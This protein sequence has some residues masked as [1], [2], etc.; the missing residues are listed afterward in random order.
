[1]NVENYQSGAI[2]DEINEA[3]SQTTND[4][5]L[6]DSN[7][8][9]RKVTFELVLKPKSTHVEITY[10]VK[11]ELPPD[12]KEGILFHSGNSLE[13]E[14]DIKEATEFELTRLD[15]YRKAGNQ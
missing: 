15:D 6:R 5:I 1:M 8:K 14:V 11:K 3:I 2:Q 9:N 7:K 4:I 12:E 10:K 13:E